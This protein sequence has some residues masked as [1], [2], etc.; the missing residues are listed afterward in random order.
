VFVSSLLR[1]GGSGAAVPS[2]VQFVG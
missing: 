1:Y 2:W